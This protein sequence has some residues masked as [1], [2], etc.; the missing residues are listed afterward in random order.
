MDTD[1]FNE[2]VGEVVGAIV[3][4]VLLIFGIVWLIKKSRKG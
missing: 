2:M 4:A 1:S 3:V